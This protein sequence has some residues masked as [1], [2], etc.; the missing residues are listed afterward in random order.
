MRAKYSESFKGKKGL[1]IG[2]FTS[3]EMRNF[4]VREVRGQARQALNYKLLKTQR[5]RSS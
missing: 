4:H 1:K 5:F 2:F 3:L